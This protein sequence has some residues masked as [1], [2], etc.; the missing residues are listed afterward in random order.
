MQVVVVSG[1]AGAG[2][3]TAARALEDM[4]F[5]CVD[6]LPAALMGTLVNLAES[7]GGEVKRVALVVDAREGRFLEAFPETFARLKDSVPDVMLIFLDARDDVLVR[8]FQETRRRHPLAPEGGAVLDGITRERAM[9]QRV[10]DLADQVIDTS[11]FN[12]H[13]LKHLVN[14][15]FGTLATRALT[16]TLLSFGYKNGL[17]AELD[18]CMDVRFLP[19]P[20]FVDELRPRDGREV[21][22]ARYVMDRPVAREFVDRYTELL[23]FLIPAYSAEGKRYLTVGVG[24]TGGQH[25]S[26]AI[27]EEL[28]K[29]LTGAGFVVRVRHRELPGQGRTGGGTA[30]G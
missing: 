13:E 8:R 21:D 22:V 20:Y 12:V 25:R 15:R 9:L 11:T 24:C 29:R 19:N 18:L 3:S 5:F 10:R 27:V 4:G 6:N 2:K 14:E 30:H 28:Q 23:R 17:P 1:L 7:S 16:V 26:V